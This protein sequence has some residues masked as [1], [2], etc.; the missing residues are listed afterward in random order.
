M[1]Y[2][3]AIGDAAPATTTVAD[4]IDVSA[5]AGAAL[6]YHGYRRTGSLIWALLYGIAGKQ[7]PAVA[8]PVA[9]AQGFGHRKNC[10]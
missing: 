1:S 6:V 10:E 9:I 3:K 5:I 7:V 2:F 8:I 4:R